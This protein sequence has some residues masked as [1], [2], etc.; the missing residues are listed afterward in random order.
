MLLLRRSGRGRGSRGGRRLLLLLLL[1]RRLRRW[2]GGRRRRRS[3]GL[4]AQRL[5]LHYRRGVGDALLVRL[6]I[7]SR[8]H[9]GGA[10]RRR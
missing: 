6:R 5:M 7:D 8:A 1:L 3:R 2:L 9:L 10:A 4:S